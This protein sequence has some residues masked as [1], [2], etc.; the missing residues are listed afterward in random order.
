VEGEGSEQNTNPELSKAYLV[1]LLSPYPAGATGKPIVHTQCQP[2]LDLVFPQD[3]TLAS[4]PPLSAPFRSLCDVVL[5]DQRIAASCEHG[6]AA[7]GGVLCV[8]WWS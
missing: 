6:V 8:W 5:A 3:L 2:A 7:G 4:Y 1:T